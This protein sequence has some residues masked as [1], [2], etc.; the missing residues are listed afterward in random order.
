MQLEHV[1]KHRKATLGRWIIFKRGG[2]QIM[3]AYTDVDYVG[4]MSDRRSI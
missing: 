2:S 3:K 1:L 4:T